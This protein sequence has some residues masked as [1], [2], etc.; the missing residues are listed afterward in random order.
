MTNV[1]LAEII[2][3]PV[4]EFLEMSA[5]PGHRNSE[6]RAAAAE[7]LKT[8]VPEHL[9]VAIAEYP[10][11][12]AP[13]GVRRV[14]M[15]GNTRAQVWKCGLSNAVPESVSARLYRMKSETEVRERML[16]HDSREQAWSAA[17]L[18][19]RAYDMTFGPEWR[20]R[21]KILAG[22]NKLTQPIR[23]AD[24]IVNHARYSPDPAVK[25]EM[26]MR[27]WIKEIQTLDNLL[28]RPV[29]NSIKEKAPFT[30]GLLAALLVILRYR[31]EQ[32]I[33]PFMQTFPDD[34]GTK[35]DAGLDGVQLLIEGLGKPRTNPDDL[36]RR[37]L[38]C[39]SLW[40]AKRAV[41][42]SFKKWADAV[43]WHQE[44]RD[45][46]RE[47]AKRERPVDAAE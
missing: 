29:S 2:S 40:E 44:Q 13:S 16:R 47:E 19:Y 27:H 22:S 41:S 36:L 21:S 20:P 4:T 17:D 24:A 5:A 12:S 46:K 7:H 14:R 8:L 35:T 37:A 11:P 28:D 39:F 42:P 6:G 9:E 32:Q 43:Q 10:D 34:G 1:E 3:L 31:D 33:A 18:M 45:A 38:T 30:Q 15:T 26:I 25:V 23:K